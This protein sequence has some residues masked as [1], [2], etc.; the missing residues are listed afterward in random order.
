MR[1]DELREKLWEQSDTRRE[2]AENQRIAIIES[3]WVEDHA[4]IM[5]NLFIELVQLE[6]DRFIQTRNVLIDYGK[7]TADSVRW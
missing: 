2:E 5:A 1:V 7:E 6:L 3:S 4:L